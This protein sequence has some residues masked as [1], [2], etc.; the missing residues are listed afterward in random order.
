MMH[1]RPVVGIRS[2]RQTWDHLGHQTN[3]VEMAEEESGAR[4]RAFEA[5]RDLEL[6]RE[7]S[8]GSRGVNDEIRAEVER[9]AAALSAETHT[10]GAEIRACQL[11]AVAVVN[12]GVD[13]ASHEVMV[14]VR[15]QPVRIRHG[16]ARAGLH[17]QP[18]GSEPVILERPSRMM[19]IES[20]AAFESAPQGGEMLQPAA[21]RREMAAIGEL[22]APANPLERKVGERR[23]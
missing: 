22:I 13:G 18:L 11:D 7:K 17:Q 12:S 20:E 1:R 14:D 16:F 19:P 23:G 8:G 2:R 5:R 6:S 21:V 10:I 15:A 9:F 3:V 4:L